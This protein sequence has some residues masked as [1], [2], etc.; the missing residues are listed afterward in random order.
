MPP[1]GLERRTGDLRQGSPTRRV[2][3]LD[4]RLAPAAVWKLDG[5]EPVARAA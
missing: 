2:L 1:G 3:R 5:L 4:A